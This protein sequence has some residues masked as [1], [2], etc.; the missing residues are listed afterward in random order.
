M[1]KK[2]VSLMLL[3]VVATSSY[4][5][6]NNLQTKDVDLSNLYLDQCEA[7]ADCEVWDSNHNLIARCVGDGGVCYKITDNLYCSGKKVN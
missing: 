2:I 5:G 6:F 3:A 4:V 1:K 7:L